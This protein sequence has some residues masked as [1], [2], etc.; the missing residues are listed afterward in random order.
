MRY[1]AKINGKTYEVEIERAEGAYK[2]V[3]RAPAA[4]QGD[5]I[6]PPP[7]PAPKPTP[8]PET[9]G[10]AGSVV[11]PMPGTVQ[12][13]KVLPG[14]AVTD[15]QTVV[16]LEAMKMEVEVKAQGAGTVSAVLVKKGDVVE[17]GAVL[18]AL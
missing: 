11:S 14:D 10:R 18:V 7:P 2:T 17:T 3:A 5:R 13:I 9:G 16:I 8:A 1:I 15:G 4:V 6:P 12:D